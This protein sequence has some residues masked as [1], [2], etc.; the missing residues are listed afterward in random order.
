YAAGNTFLDALAAYRRSRGLP[1][2]SVAWGLWAERSGMTG[3]LGDTD[4]ARMNRMGAG[5]LSTRD[6]LDLFDRAIVSPE[7]LVL[8]ARL[9]TRAPGA[10]DAPAHPMLRTLVRRPAAPRRRRLTAPG[11]GT[12]TADRSTAL[13]RSLLGQRPAERR[14]T[15]LDLVRAQVSTVLGHTDADADAVAPDRAFKD[16]GLDSLTAVDLRNRLGAATGLRLPATL[17]FDH[18]DC[19][20]LAGHLLTEILGEE[21]TAVAP[22]PQEPGSS[23]ASAADDPIAIIGMACRYPG[24]VTTPEDLWDLVAS[25]GDAIGGLPTDRGWDLDAL[26]DP[27]PDTPG[28]MYVRE[29][30]FL[31]DAARF[32][33]EFFGIS[34]VEALAT[35]PQQRLLLETS[36]EA[37]ERAGIVPAAL[38]GSRTGVFVGSHYQE[39][40]PRLHEAG[41]GT[42]GHLLTGT[43]GSVVSGRV[44]YVMG[45]EGP[46]VTVDTACSS[47]LVALH[48]AVRALREGE[49]DLALAGGVAVMPGPGALVGFSRQRGL[50]PDG[51]C[52]PFAAGADGTSLAEGA[53]VLLVERLSDARRN[54]HRV[55]ALVR[56]TATNQD[57]ASNGLSA[58]NGPA[59]QRVIRAALADA[60]LTAADIDVVEAH[61]TGT[62]LGDPI[63]A[64]AVLATY[65][66]RRGDGADAR[67]VRLGS[68]KSNIGHTQAAAGVAGIIKTVHAMR[69]GVLPRSLHLDEPS[70]HVDWSSGGVGLLR[71]S[72]DWPA[73]ERP[74][75]AGV[76]SFGISGTNAHVI[77]EEAPEEAPEE[78]RDGLPVPVSGVRGTDAPAGTVAWVVSGRSPAA[79]RE[80]ARRLLAHLRRL[81]DDDVP[82]PRDLAVAL[83]TRRSVF[84]R[85]AVVVGEERAD[86]VAGLDA[87]AAGRP[88]PRLVVGGAPAGRTAFLFT[89]QGSQ[90]A[91]MAA[92]L[93]R[94]YPVFADAF[95]A[96]CARF[97]AL[98]PDEPSLRDVV[99]DTGEDA[100]STLSGTLHAQCALFA[101]EIALYRLVTSWGVRPDVVAGH[102]VGEIAAAH[103]A[104]VLTLADACALVAARGRLMRS[105][106]EGGAMVAVRLSEADVAPLLEGRA[107]DIGVAAVNGPDSV[108]LSGA[109]DAVAEIVARLEERGAR[110]RRLTVSHAFHSPLME[111]VLAPL[112]DELATLT[113][114]VPEIP[115][116]S[117]LTGELLPGDRPVE[118]EHWVRHVREPVRFADGVAA[119]AAQGVTTF[120][121]IGP[122]AV[123]STLGQDSAPEAGFVPALLAEG[124]EAAALTQAL[125]QLFARG[126]DID[127]PAALGVPDNAPH[128]VDLPTYAFQRA[129]YWLPS[130][131]RAPSRTA[132]GSLLR[133]AADGADDDALAAELSLGDAESTAALLPLLAAYRRRRDEDRLVDGWRYRTAWAPVAVPS[134]APAG[135]WLVAV[136]A[137]LVTDPWVTGLV[138]A[139]SAAGTRPVTVP[140]TGT[141]TGTDAL[142]GRLGAAVSGVGAVSGV[143]SLLALATGRHPA[144]DAVPRSVALTLELLRAL[145]ETGLRVPVWHATR[146]AAAVGGGERVVHPEQFGVRA[147]GRVAV[148]EAHEHWTGTV[149]LPE[150]IDGWIGGRLAAVLDQ[151]TGAPVDDHTA[152]TVAGESELAVRGSGVFARRVAHAPAPAPAPGPSGP[153]TPAHPARPADPVGG[154]GA[155]TGTSTGTATPWPPTGTV[156][157]TGGTGALGRQVALRLAR[158]GAEHLLLVSRRGPAAEG[159][160]ALRAGLTALGTRTDLVACDVGDRAAVAALLEGVPAERPLTAVV[161]TAGTPDDGALAQQTVAGFQEVLRA[162]AESA[163][164]LHDLTRERTDLT[165][166]VLFS[167]FAATAGAVGRTHQ[168]V[169]GALLAALAEERRA[170]GLPV[171]CVAWGPW[172][173]TPA[174]DGPVGHGGLIPMRPDLAL[175]ALERAVSGE[176]TRIA[177]LHA[178]GELFA[179]HLAATPGARP[180]ARLFDGVPEMRRAASGIRAYQDAGHVQD[181]ENP[182]EFGRRLTALPATERG[183]ELLRLVRVHA[184]LVLG[185]DTGDAVAPERSFVEMGFDSLTATRMRNRLGAVTGLQISAATVFA[186][187]TP[188]TLADHLLRLYAAPHARRRPRLRPRGRG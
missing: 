118:P 120:L 59:Q 122:D 92:E 186:H 86:L 26:Y 17:A 181:S 108:V 35:D 156:L 102:S 188:D 154:P 103:V 107:H 66:A 83:A 178:D 131:D 56:G 161:H 159:A 155:V 143:L 185:H 22:A 6:G 61:G 4:L 23:A 94:T 148:L 8:A 70:D 62:R 145:D 30:G 65:G 130:D 139:L 41:H 11:T 67:P 37:V 136:P 177:V 15:A 53:G 43:A 32:D 80:Q 163:R 173:E 49:C 160:D 12:G 19:T 68:V 138:A 158:D 21:Q 140:V 73:T 99:F 116:M 126:I 31:H 58:P 105:L 78:I 16:L 81:P 104:G 172:A 164:H 50:A 111:P 114:A 165:S 132:A 69:H 90:R 135:D 146:S 183:A 121:E 119:L 96:V 123:L 174:E 79:L 13:R 10:D 20:A 40:G 176:D 98:L 42:E 101:V 71:D 93:Y 97:D 150:R 184:A 33:A 76:S 106:P 134:A 170:E 133:D 28:R 87:L 48:M 2:V 18:P 60:R 72:V 1:G 117:H 168:A 36:W 110:T 95:D 44:S 175:R 128:T 169:A 112:R 82:A 127:W 46:A 151:G 38:R 129:D 47:S 89:G 125:A 115:V 179:D 182:E 153:G 25:G 74:R 75:R 162:E 152:G 9:D 34:P 27:D 124:G 77:V 187:P 54:G 7:S 142:A 29:G 109:A 52:K 167:S 51:R 141:G 149:D 144:H 85:R 84:E 137:D 147:L 39:Y 157:I 5:A 64:Q 55:L 166:F 3:H 24:G 171:T 180:L 100:G 14:A 45:L 63:E 88:A 91:G 57:G 113:C